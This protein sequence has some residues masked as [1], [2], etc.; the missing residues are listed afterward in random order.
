MY[1]LPRH[2]DA[3]YS[4]YLTAMQREYIIHRAGPVYYVFCE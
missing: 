3:T 2:R 1:V 4:V